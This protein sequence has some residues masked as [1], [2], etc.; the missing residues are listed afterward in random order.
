MK[1]FKLKPGQLVALL[2]LITVV[3]LPLFSVLS[4]IKVQ[5]VKDLLD[6]GQFVSLFMNS[7]TTTLVAT[8][9]SVGLALT[10]AWFINRSGIRYKGMLSVM[11]TLPMLIPSISHGMGL[12]LMLG[13]N[14]WITN[15][16]GI[17]FNLFGF[18]GIVIGSIM[19]SFPVAFLMLNDVFRYEDYT[20]Y[21]MADILNIPKFKQM[22]VI[23]LL[24]L[25]VPLISAFFAVFTMIFTDY[26]V[27]LIVGGKT[28]TLSTYMY[29]EVIGLL[30]FSK[31]A[32][33]G[34]ILL[35]PA[36]I[37]FILDLRNESQANTSTIVKKFKI[38]PNAT[39]DTIGY[40]ICIIVGILTLLPLGT[41]IVLSF[42]TQYPNNMT[43][44]LVNV[45]K[46][47]TFGVGHY[48]LNGLTIALVTGIT[49]VISTYS[50]AYITARSRKSFST[51][52]L[53]LISMVSL[54]I[55]GVVLGLSYVLFF[56]GS[57][58]Y[59]TLY[60]LILVNVVHFFASPYL[61][62]YNSLKNF[63]SNLEDVSSTL[64]ISRYRMLM[65]VYVPCTKETIVEMFSYLFVNAMVTI[66]AISFLANL[67]NMPLSLLIPQFDA[68][69]LLEPTAFISVLIFS[70][71]I[72][73]KVIIYYTKK[74][75]VKAEA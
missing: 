35:I 28:L 26:G 51:M 17:N 44:S 65:D 46:A 62:A 3:I 72:V 6:S 49:G 73:L 33:I 38:K 24:Q 41:F 37:A 47:F 12:V 66:S 68:Q 43:F 56:N 54:A 8:I 2:F 13:D 21:E 52:A 23:T 60:I 67:R 1:K 74:I 50:I 4:H 27:P 39:R 69:S 18:K 71:N 7:L 32:I 45:K 30:N 20:T 55:P 34:V 59:G 75:M 5:D 31:G 70:V 11:F 19:Y 53:H 58:I 61:L 48:L 40:I 42:V 36:L 25:K 64:N 15:L 29:R 16:T 22:L 10:L 63:N 57:P 14:G 9:I